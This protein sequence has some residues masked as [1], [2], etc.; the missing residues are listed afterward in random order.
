MKNATSRYQKQSEWN[1]NKAKAVKVIKKGFFF[2]YYAKA[3]CLLTYTASIFM[4]FSP[5]LHPSHYKQQQQ[6]KNTHIGKLTGNEMCNKKCFYK[7]FLLY[8]FCERQETDTHGTSSCTTSASV[9]LVI[10]DTN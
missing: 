4:Y 7:L 5:A 10:C 6:H 3:S 8:F 9:L 1:E 2:I